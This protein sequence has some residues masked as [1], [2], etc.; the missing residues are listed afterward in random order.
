MGEVVVTRHAGLRAGQRDVRRWLS[1]LGSLVVP[2]ATTAVIIAIWEG[3]VR[4]FNIPI[5]LMPPPSAV[6]TEIAQHSSLLFQQSLVTTNESLLAFGLSIVVGIPLGVVITASKTVEKIVY[7]LLVASQ[8]V[9]KV[10]IA[11]LLTIWLGFGLEPKVVVGALVAVFPIVIATVVGLQSVT[12]EMHYLGRSM[13][14]D[15]VRMFFKIGL[16]Q[17]LPSIMGGLKVAIALAVVGAIVGEFTGADRGLGYL[18]ERSVGVLDTRQMFA[19]LV[20][21]VTVGV[22][23]FG[24]VAWVETLVIRHPG[25]GNGSMRVRESA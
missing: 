5:F 1:P 25:A 4:V 22:V 23:L 18:L 7:P 2:L 20:C 3:A 9:P 17:A 11:P 13:G 14:L 21:L 24:I 15:P 8:A 19:A 12:T 10:A 6:A 16:P